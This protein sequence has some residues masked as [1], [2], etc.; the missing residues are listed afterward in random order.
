MRLACRPSCRLVLA[1]ILTVLVVTGSRALAQQAEIAGIDK[2]YLRPAPGT[3]QTPLGVLSVGD[4]V[5]ILDIEGSWTKIETS[6]GKV[7]YVY[8]RYVVPLSEGGIPASAPPTPAAPP[9][10]RA[11]GLPPATPRAAGAPLTVPTSAPLP[12]ATLQAAQPSMQATPDP[13]QAELSTLRSELT[14]LREKVQKRAAEAPG[15]AATPAA[16]E[17]AHTQ[18]GSSE[19]GMSVLAVAFVFLLIGWVLGAAFH[20][21][22]NKSSRRRLRL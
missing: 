1:A 5:N 4:R 22:R 20:G 3:D 18:Q 21:R 12:L 7:G 9:T 2:V 14:E 15:A 11:F 16:V 13:L 19:P 10:P 8:H 6:D 17:T